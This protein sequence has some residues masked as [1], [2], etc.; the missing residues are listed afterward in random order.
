MN[1]LDRGRI[2]YVDIERN[3]RRMQAE[4]IANG[5]RHVGSWLRGALKR[6]PKAEGQPL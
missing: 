5:M 1:H 4:A 2:D 6:H 3:A